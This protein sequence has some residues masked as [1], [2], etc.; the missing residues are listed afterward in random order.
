MLPISNIEHQVVN[1]S[2]SNTNGERVIRMNLEEFIE[3]NDNYFETTKHYVSY[4]PYCI[5]TYGYEKKK[6]YIEKDTLAKGF[7]QR[8]H[9][10]YFN[11]TTDLTF[12]VAYS[13]S[14]LK[15]FTLCKLNEIN[16]SLNA[17]YSLAMYH[18]SVCNKDDILKV[19]SKRNLDKITNI[20]DNILIKR[21]LSRYE[22]LIDKLGMKGSIID[23]DQSFVMVPFYINNELVYWQSKLAGYKMKYFMPPIEHKPLYI[24]EYRG[25]KIV[26]VE[27]IFDAMACLYLFPNRTPIAVLGSY[28]TDYHLWLLRTYIQPTDCLISLDNLSL[29]YNI[30][31]Q[32]KGLIPTIT[33]YSLFQSKYDQD[34]DEFLLSLSDD[35]LSEFIKTHKYENNFEWE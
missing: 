28:L 2:Q 21:N 22:P 14:K 1:I 18:K 15:Q 3:N 23:E 30:L 16:T 8:C 20:G 11:Y 10:I 7:C 35:E 5:E 26:I 33:Q 24:P 27:G 17:D 9:S 32:L 29:S 12:D 25:T 31:F 4:C 6:L 34:P 13:K 19:L